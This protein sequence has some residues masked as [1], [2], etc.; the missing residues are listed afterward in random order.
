MI[1]YDSEIIEDPETSDRYLVHSMYGEPEEESLVL[2]QP[3][4]S[5]LSCQEI[6]IQ[7]PLEGDRDE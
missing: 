5:L 4:E 7:R 3:L 1:D 2:Q 6:I